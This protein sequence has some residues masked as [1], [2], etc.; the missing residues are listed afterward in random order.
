MRLIFH[1]YKEL[2]L[3]NTVIS[4]CFGLSTYILLKAYGFPTAFMT[5]GYILSVGYFEMSKKKQYYF[6]F[7]RGLSKM[8]LYLTSFII[9]SVIGFLFVLTIMLCEN[10]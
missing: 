4:I 6:Y 10:F 2:L 1:Y 7:N 9:N 5:A 8:Q 3:L